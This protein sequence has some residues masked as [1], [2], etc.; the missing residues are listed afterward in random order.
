MYNTHH[1]RIHELRPDKIVID[2]KE[3]TGIKLS[4]GTE[5]PPSMKVI[6]GKSGFLDY[7]KDTN[8]DNDHSCI[9]NKKEEVKTEKNE[10]IIKDPLDKS[11]VNKKVIKMGLFLFT[12]GMICITFFLFATSPFM[13][14]GIIGYY[15]NSTGYMFLTASVITTLAGLTMASIPKD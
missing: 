9:Y 6:P 13:T 4:D 12:M 11:C 15:I 3:G 7:Y 5:I 2:F 10:D 1:K 8:K 14:A